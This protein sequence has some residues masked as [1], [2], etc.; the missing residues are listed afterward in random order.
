[1]SSKSPFAVNSRILIFFAISIICMGI[2]LVF[3]G[4]IWIAPLITT[5]GI[6]ILI[7]QWLFRKDRNQ[8]NK[9]PGSEVNEHKS[10]LISFDTISYWNF[11]LSRIIIIILIFG[12]AVI[13][14][15]LF[16][17]PLVDRYNPIGSWQILMGPTLFYPL[18]FPIRSQR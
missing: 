1:M 5:L 13:D 16:R 6:G 10:P 15:A 12:L 18:V 14:A 8:L 3:F 4:Q 7:K 9:H 2:T 17:T 11:P